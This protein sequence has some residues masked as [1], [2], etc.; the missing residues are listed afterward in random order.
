MRESIQSS[1]LMAYFIT[2]KIDVVTSSEM[3]YRYLIVKA[4]PFPPNITVQLL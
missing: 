4:A 1:T 3:T 2:E